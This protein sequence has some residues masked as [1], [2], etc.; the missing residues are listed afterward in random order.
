MTT[1][2]RTIIVLQN[3]DPDMPKMNI[4]FLGALDFLKTLYIYTY[5]YNERMII[6]YPSLNVQICV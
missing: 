4:I 6:C 5:K 3:L 1:N 2:D